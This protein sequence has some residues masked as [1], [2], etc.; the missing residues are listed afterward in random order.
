M[1]VYRSISAWKR[2]Y[3]PKEYCGNDTRTRSFSR[4][5]TCLCR[6][7]TIKVK[8][9]VL[10]KVRLKY[11][12]ILTRIIYI[13]YRSIRDE[14]DERL[15]LRDAIEKRPISLKE[16]EISLKSLK[17]LTFLLTYETRIYNKIDANLFFIL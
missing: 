10:I 4:T 11:V 16:P 2:D 14:G 13:L 15:P 12:H 17:V 3:L 9:S 8:E 5:N 7:Y 1:H 6:K